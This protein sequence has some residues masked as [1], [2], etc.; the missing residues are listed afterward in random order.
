MAFPVVASSAASNRSTD[1][2]THNITM[3][4]GIAAGDLLLV[5]FSFSGFAGST[6]ATASAGWT[7]LGQANQSTNTTA[8]A[9]V[10]WKIA[11]GSDTLT[12]TTT[13]GRQSTAVAA[14]ITGGGAVTGTSSVGTS[15][16]GNPPSHNP[17]GAGDILWI[18]TWTGEGTVIPSV[19]PA[20][21]TSLMNVSGSGLANAASSTAYRPESIATMDPGPFT[22]S[23]RDWV[24]WTLAVAPPIAAGRLLERKVSGAWVPQVVEKK[25]SGA[26]VPQIIERKDAGVWS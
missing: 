10:F 5:L 12:V 22:N 20:G 1:V 25:V 11:A 4:A 9:A 23:S 21:F 19:L 6:V 2:S 17:P 7:K 3:P 16:S 26:W 13:D 8:F 24:C 18:A 15:N 14:R